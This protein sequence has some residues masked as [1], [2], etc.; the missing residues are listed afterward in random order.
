MLHR[1]EANYMRS[2]RAY[3]FDNRDSAEMYDYLEARIDAMKEIV[4]AAVEIR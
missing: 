4:P 2:H 1:V 3:E